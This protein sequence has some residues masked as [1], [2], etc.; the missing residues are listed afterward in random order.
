MAI[1]KNVEFQGDKVVNSL[2]G[3][4]KINQTTGEIIIS[5]NGVILTRINKDGFV[6]SE[7]DG[8]RRILIGKHPKTG[9]VIEAI[10]KAGVDVI[11][12]LEKE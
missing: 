6:Y 7:E 12:E 2:G 10:S 1:E 4:I 9:N 3:N 5:N 8:T 11:S